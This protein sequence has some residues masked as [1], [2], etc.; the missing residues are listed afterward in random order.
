MRDL[1]AHPDQL[2]QPLRVVAQ[3]RAQAVVDDAAFVHH[4][5]TVREREGDAAVL[6]DQHDR[7]PALAAQPQILQV[8]SKMRLIWFV[9][10]G[11]VDSNQARIKLDTVTICHTR[12]KVANCS[13][14][15]RSIV[16][17]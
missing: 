8:G 16:A 17:R 14:A 4:H 12:N 5:A 9:D 1:F 6:L 15:P 2:R 11:R 7:Q 13:A 10:G 3:R